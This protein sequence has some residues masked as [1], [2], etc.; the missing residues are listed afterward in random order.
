MKVLILCVDFPPLNS[1]GAQR[2]Y[3]WYRYFHERGATVTV[4][5]KR[6]KKHT[7][8]PETLLQQASTLKKKQVE[9]TRMGKIIR[10][11]HRILPNEKLILKYGMN[12]KVRQ[13]KMLTLLYRWFSFPFTS[14]DQ[15]S[16]MYREAV[17]ELAQQKFDVVIT[18]GRP[19]ILFKYGYRL[20]KKHK[21]FWVADYRDGWYLNHV[22]KLAR[23]T[24][25]ALL[26]QHELKYE[27][28]YLKQADLIST[29]DPLL[30]ADLKKM[31]QKPAIYSYNGFWEF[32]R[33]T[34]KIAP[35]PRLVLTHTGTL[36]PGQRVE[37]LLDVVQ[38]LQQEGIA[39]ASNLFIRFTGLD[40]FPDQCARIRNAYPA[41]KTMIATTPR[42]DMQEALNL[43]TA[44]DFLLSFTEASSQAIYAKTYDYVACGRPI[45][46]LPDD[47]SILGNFVRELGAG[48]AF[49]D[50][51]ELKIFLRRAILD[52]QTGKT[53]DHPTTHLQKS[54]QYT[55]R[56]QAHAYIDQLKEAFQT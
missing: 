55:R 7:S 42:I 43:N 45:L 16:N 2:P 25:Q 11:P 32:H 17:A 56:A 3:A 29:V 4:I 41:L 33:P 18:T 38:E 20:R 21:L 37:F 24:L 51:A 5:T 31:H 1:I 46:V 35:D 48:N 10:L 30:A 22:M 26:R 49:G 6:W 40:Y 36:T 53:S 44:S 52:K 9:V 34:R 54:A 14:F 19:F 47:H 15:Y 39:K 23:G 50:K 8:S 13:R 28:R 27:K 12:K